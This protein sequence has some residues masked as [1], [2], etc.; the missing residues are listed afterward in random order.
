MKENNKS[1]IGL[2]VD[3]LQRLIDIKESAND[4]RKYLKNSKQAPFDLIYKRLGGSHTSS[5]RITACSLS[6]YLTSNNSKAPMSNLNLLVALNS[7]IYPY[8]HLTE[9]K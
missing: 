7:N 3:F 2:T 1:S 5:D 9:S 4:A 6:E 8:T